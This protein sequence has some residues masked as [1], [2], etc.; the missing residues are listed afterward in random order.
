MNNLLQNRLNRILN[1]ITSEEFL[2]SRGL[3]NEIG[4]WIFEYTPEDEL[5]V[6]NHVRFILDQLERK[7]RQ[8]KVVEINLLEAIKSY[9]DSRNF[10]D[11]AF[12]LQRTK[13][14]TALL[15]VLEGPLHM[16]RFAPFLVEQYKATEQDIIFITGIGSVWPMMRAHHLLNSLHA[17]LGH[18]PL[19]MFYPGVYTGQSMSLFGRIPSKHYYRAFKL[20][21]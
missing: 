17:S 18:R 2:Q 3:G 9:L 12:K 15:K 5:Q 20:A 8:I 19:V 13:G 4:F 7:F 21:P 14:D 1:I 11:K 10:S 6:R 16:D